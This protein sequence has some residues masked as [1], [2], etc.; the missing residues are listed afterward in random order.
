MSRHQAQLQPTF[1]RLFRRVR[2]PMALLASLLVLAQAAALAEET[3]SADGNFVASPSPADPGLTSLEIEIYWTP[4]RMAAAQP[5]PLPIVEVDEAKASPDLPYASKP[6]GKPRLEGGGP[7]QREY[8]PK[9]LEDDDV[10]DVAVPRG[11]GVP[12][13]K[14]TGNANVDYPA[15][16]TR[17]TWFGRYLTYPISTIAKMF[18]DQDH[19]GDGVLSSFVCSASVVDM[20]GGTV[21]RVATAGHCVNNGLNG[22][23][24]NGGWST[25]VLVCPSYNAGGVN[26]VSGCWAVLNQ[27]TYT[28]WI[29]SS[30][31]DLD[32]ACMH[33]NPTGTVVANE[34]GNV[35]GTL[36]RAWNW[37]DEPITAFGYPAGAPFPG[38]H[39]I[40][41]ASAD[42]Y[43][44]DWGIG[45]D[46]KYIG[47]DQ[48]G[49]S[50]GGPWILGLEHRT[51]G[52]PDT[53]G[54][55]ATDP[56]TGG[57]SAAAGFLDGVN[58]H[59]R[60]CGGAACVC[61]APFALCSQEMGGPNFTNAAGGTEDLFAFCATF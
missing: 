54:S 11:F 47:S 10:G 48:T 12:Q 33:T 56:P 16:F 36:G 35:T 2:T 17:W 25:N 18:F 26:P 55:G 46:S 45:P 28:G 8:L 32:I 52:Y 50:S 42:W 61:G 40:I 51:A 7:P 29:T 43:N 57:P 6:R 41:S 49:G 1:Q 23:G 22:A 15:P 39:I 58:S 44:V 59:K 13:N 3:R 5:Y 4:E 34:I 27:A 31:S 38:Y 19:D 60:V 37:N 21:D 9:I 53:D 14:H 20:G 24:A 30:N